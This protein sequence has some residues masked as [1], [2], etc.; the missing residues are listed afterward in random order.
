MAPVGFGALIP[1]EPFRITVKLLLRL[2]VTA[3]VISYYEWKD[4]PLTT[5][6]IEWDPYINSF[7]V[8]WKEIKDPKKNDDS[9]LPKISNTV[10]IVKWFEAYESH[11]YAVIG[12]ANAPLT[13]IIREIF[14]VSPIEPEVSIGQHHSTKHGSVKLEIVQRL[15]HTKNIYV[16]DNTIVYSHIV[17]E[18]LGTQ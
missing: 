9:I 4:R 14:V 2:K 13:W 11:A 5:G 18:T 17:K 15:P 7:S 8:H 6:N 3:V 10:K 16:E 1:Q 12:Q